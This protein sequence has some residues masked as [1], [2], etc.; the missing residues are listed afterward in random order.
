M[1]LLILILIRGQERHLLNIVRSVS[2]IEV[3][4]TVVLFRFPFELQMYEAVARYAP[5]YLFPA[6]SI[7]NGTVR[8]DRMG[9]QSLVRFLQGGAF[10]LAFG[11]VLGGEDD[12]VGLDAAAAAGIPKAIAHLG[13]MLVV[14]RVCLKTIPDDTK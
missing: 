5:V 2:P 6:S 7:V 9:F 3:E 11:V 1:H 8:R 14:I 13:A 10:D 4:P 12:M